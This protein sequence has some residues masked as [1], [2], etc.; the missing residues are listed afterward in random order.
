MDAYEH[1]R[2]LGKGAMGSVALVRR[3]ADGELLALK[4]MAVHSAKDRALARNEIEILR[5]LSHPHVVRFEDTF[6]LGQDVCIVMQFCEGGD[7]ARL[8][9]EQRSAGRKLPEAE[10]RGLLAQLGSALAHM[11]ALRIV[12]RDI[13]SSNVFLLGAN[14]AP[15]GALGATR[16]ALLGDF[17]V[18]KALESTRAMACTQCGTPYYLPPEVCNG[19]QYNAKADMWSLGVL[20]YELCA[21]RY[22]F[23]AATLPALVM[24]IVAGKVRLRLRLGLRL[25]LRLSPNPNPNPN[26]NQVHAAAERGSVGRA[27][28]SRLHD[29]PSA[30]EGPA[31]GR[32][33]R[34]ARRAAAAAITARSRVRSRAPAH[35]QRIPRAQATAQ[36]RLR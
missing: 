3:K 25:R 17:G 26:P 12:Y 7:L 13:K 22:P 9:G 4:S 10:V 14:A 32:A 8:I 23:A 19:A 33:A 35:H 36:R 18:S 29:A 27:A 28:R 30:A 15:G 2:A 5:K 16:H 1:Q 24:A 20:A 31:L 11:H 34:A 6:V 21:L